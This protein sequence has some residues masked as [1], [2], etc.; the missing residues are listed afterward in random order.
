MPFEINEQVSK[1]LTEKSHRKFTEI[2]VHDIIRPIN[3]IKIAFIDN[4]TLAQLIEKYGSSSFCFVLFLK[5]KSRFYL[6]G[7]S[8]FG[9]AL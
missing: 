2:N 4:T 1:M 3:S 5:K 7:H 9:K 8:T 6:T